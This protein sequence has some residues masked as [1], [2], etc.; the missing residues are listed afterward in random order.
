M[1]AEEQTALQNWYENL[2]HEEELI[3]NNSGSTENSKDLRQHLADTTRQV[4]DTSREVETLVVQ[5]VALRNENQAL[6]NS[7]IL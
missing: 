6:R 5:N 2:D 7:L 4:A 3:L 1:T